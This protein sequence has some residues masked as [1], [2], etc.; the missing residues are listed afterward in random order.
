MH[1]IWIAISAVLWITGLIYIFK[2]INEQFRI[3]HEINLKL[4]SDKQFEPKFW[5]FGNYEEFRELQS[6]LLPD[7][8]RPGRLRRFQ[9]IGCAL[10]GAG[11]LIFILVT[12]LGVTR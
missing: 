7:S 4:P 3:Q 2:S 12:E 11:V 5:W 10:S 6:K 1:T 9:W 8:P